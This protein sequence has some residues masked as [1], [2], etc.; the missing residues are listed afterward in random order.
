MGTLAL[1]SGKDP[2]GLNGM[3]VTATASLLQTATPSSSSSATINP[4]LAI[5][6]GYMITAVPSAIPNTT[7]T[8]TITAQLAFTPRPP[9][10]VY[11]LVSATLV[12]TG[13][14]PSAV[15][16]SPAAWRPTAALGSTTSLSQN[17]TFSTV[18]SSPYAAVSS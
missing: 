15:M 4:V 3:I 7:V 9:P 14:P 11:D 1:V 5:P 16:P 18:P 8:G 2:L 6:D 12:A 10:T 13:T 17:V